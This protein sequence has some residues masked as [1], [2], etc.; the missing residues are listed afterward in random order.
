M[1]GQRADHADMTGISMMALTDEYEGG[2]NSMNEGEKLVI[3]G[4]GGG[5]FAT[6]MRAKALMPKIEVTLVRKEKRFIVRCSLP[7]VVSGLV[8]GESIVNPDQKFIDAGINVIVDEVTRVD[9]KRKKVRLSDGRELPYDKLVMATG[10]SP[11]VPPIEGRDLDGVFTFR[12]LS[13]A[14]KMAVF[15]TEKKVKKM[16][17]IGAGFITME[18]AAAIMTASPG[19]YDITIVEMLEHPLP[20]MLDTEFGAK[21]QEY[22]TEKGLKMKM[23]RK[24]TK[25]LGRDGAVSGVELESGEKL[26][27]DMMVL[28]VGVKAN[29]ELAKQIGLDIGAYGVKTNEYMETSEPDIFAL[30][31]CVEKK[32][33]ITGKPVP[34]VLRGP[35]IIAGRHVA[36]KLAGYDVPFPGVLD[37]AVAKLLDKCIGFTGL[38]EKR[39]REEGYDPVCATV[40]SRSKHAMMPGVKPWTIK[41]VFDRKSK[42]LLG[43]QILSDS[44]APVKEIDT[45]NALILG[46]KTVYDLCSIMCAGQPEL[47]SEPS[48]EPISIAAEQ[49][50][51]KM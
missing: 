42:K 35:A 38:T 49:A 36:K 25:I 37:N 4:G 50:L 9:P 44:E 47:S 14:E 6:A 26:D 11:V 12:S 15:I 39:A 20:L 29:L 40:E 23:G 18:L 10:G 8:T 13:D 17:F 5:G 28:N 32:H 43:G 22:L 3:I 34:G 46:G 2:E 21:L 7:Y 30:G 45:V 33:F 48:A 24:V 16:V 31:D 19:Q 41:L 27:A 51:V 1:G